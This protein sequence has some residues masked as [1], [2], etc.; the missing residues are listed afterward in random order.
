M[1]VALH[2]ATSLL[3]ETETGLAKSEAGALGLADQGLEGF[4]V[5]PAVERM[6][7]RL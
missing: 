3:G 6:G 5:E 7:D 4:V 1:T 2:L